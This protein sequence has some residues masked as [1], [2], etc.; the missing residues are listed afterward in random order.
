MNKCFH[1]GYYSDGWCLHH[2]TGTSPVG[3][4]KHWRMSIPAAP[5]GAQKPKK[6]CGNCEF[7]N[8]S[9]CSNPNSSFFSSAISFTSSCAS[10]RSNGIETTI[11]EQTKTIGQNLTK[12]Q[13]HK[14][15][16]VPDFRREDGVRCNRCK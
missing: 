1:C 4:C 9:K 5:K 7:Y 14:V 10:F 6:I 15:I 2:R 8:A 3:G 16:K 11:D 13:P 12:N